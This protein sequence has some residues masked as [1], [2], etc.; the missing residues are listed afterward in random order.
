MSVYDEILEKKKQDR[1]KYR[2]EQ[3]ERDNEDLKRKNDVY[4]T[5][6][7]SMQKQIDNKDK[8]IER[9][10]REIETKDRWIEI[11]DRWCQNII[12]IGCDY[13]GCN[14]VSS[15]KSLIDELVDYSKKAIKCD[16]TTPVYISENGKKE[17][18][19]FEEL[20]ESTNG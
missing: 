2:L 13:D 11:K 17:N 9:L 7:Y 18:I 20:K 19:L 14:K 5:K 15:L 8:E 10:N 4:A 1:I 12:S 3:E 16:D 6:F